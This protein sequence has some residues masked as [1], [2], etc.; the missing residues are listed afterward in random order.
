[1]IAPPGDVSD[2]DLLRRWLVE[3]DEGETF[4]TI[5]G[6]FRQEVREALEAAGLQPMEAEDRVGAVFARA[7]ATRHE[8]PPETPLRHR[9][10]AVARGVAADVVG[11]QLPSD[12]DK[13]PGGR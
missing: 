4:L 6:R 9:L 12:G 11:R 7:E 3:A 13:E 8:L 10:L 2:T 5:Y 1:M